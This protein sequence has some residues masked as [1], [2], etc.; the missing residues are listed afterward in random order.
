[1]SPLLHLTNGPAETR[2]KFTFILRRRTDLVTMIMTRFGQI[3]LASINSAPPLFTT[4]GAGAG[5]GAAASSASE[6]V[7][8]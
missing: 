4:F 8:T 6:G 2:P 3:M 7:V 1:V 5:G